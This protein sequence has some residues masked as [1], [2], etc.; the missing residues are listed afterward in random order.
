VKD[1]LK[2]VHKLKIGLNM[3]LVSQVSVKFEISPSLKLYTNLIIH[4]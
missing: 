3:F 1:M 4:I 2:I